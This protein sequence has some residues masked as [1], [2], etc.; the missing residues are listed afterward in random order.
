MFRRP[1]A[2][3]VWVV[4]LYAG[5]AQEPPVRIAAVTGSEAEAMILLAELAERAPG[6]FT[7]ADERPFVGA[8]GVPAEPLATGERRSVFV[9]HEDDESVEVFELRDDAKARR[10][11]WAAYRIGE[12]RLV[13]AVTNTW[14]EADPR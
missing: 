3:D 4:H 11:E 10:G 7:M 1:S 6:C 14:L 8:D 2:A 13:A 9:V 5:A 12:V